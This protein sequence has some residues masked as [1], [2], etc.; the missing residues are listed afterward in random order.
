MSTRTRLCPQPAGPGRT[1]AHG[2]PVLCQILSDTKE[3]QKEIN[4][5]SG[6]LDR[7]FA[8]TDELVFKVWAWLG[9]VGG[10]RGAGWAPACL[11]A[12]RLA[13]ASAWCEPCRY[14]AARAWLCTTEDEVRGVGEGGPMGVLEGVFGGA[15][16]KPTGPFCLVRMPRRMMPFGR[17]TSI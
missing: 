12:H 11:S 6:K 13:W 1:W 3:L 17:H 4:S 14:T 9:R 7:T 16:G 10:R 2:C 8:V 15:W 5:L